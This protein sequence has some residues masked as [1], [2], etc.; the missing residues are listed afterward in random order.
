MSRSNCDYPQCPE[1]PIHIH[2][3]TSTPTDTSTHTL[4]YFH[5]P[6]F[7]EGTGVFYSTA[8]YCL[9]SSS[10]RLVSAEGPT[11]SILDFAGHIQSVVYSFFFFFY[12][13]FKR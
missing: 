7:Q 6:S 5:G 10:L 4:L 2:T 3:F 1:M 8:A 9:Q 12:N 13:L 11:V